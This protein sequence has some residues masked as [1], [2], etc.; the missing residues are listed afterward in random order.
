MYFWTHTHRHLEKVSQHNHQS[1]RLEKALLS[2]YSSRW[3]LNQLILYLNQHMHY[4]CMHKKFGTILYRKGGDILTSLSLALAYMLMI[5]IKQITQQL[6]ITD[7]LILHQAN[8][9][10]N[11][12]LQEESKR[13]SKEESS[14]Y[15]LQCGEVLK[16]YK[17]VI[18]AIFNIISKC[19]SEGQLRNH[20]KRLIFILY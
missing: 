14:L 5:M 4:K 3:L 20:V 17:P 13:L 1:W 12:L 18:G 16:R 2:L 6:V 11:C 7:K 10:I 9:I 15:V 8:K 19:T